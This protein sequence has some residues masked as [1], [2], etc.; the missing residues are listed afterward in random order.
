MEL[1]PLAVYRP[2]FTI[3]GKPGK[4]DKPGSRLVIEPGRYSAILAWLA[5]GDT[6]TEHVRELRQ[7]LTLEGVEPELAGVG[8]A[9]PNALLDSR[10]EIAAS[11]EVREPPFREAAMGLISILA[12]FDQKYFHRSLTM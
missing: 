6:R 9:S 2:T 12:G 11:I 3:A 1:R 5:E 7:Y 10:P 8:G 4:F